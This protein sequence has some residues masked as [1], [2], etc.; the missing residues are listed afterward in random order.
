MPNLLH[1]KIASRFRNR[2][3]ESAK[4][5]E[6]LVLL[7]G[8]FAMLEAGKC[9]LREYGR[10]TGEKNEN[11]CADCASRASEGDGSNLYA[12]WATSY[13]S[14]DGPVRSVPS[15]SSNMPGAASTS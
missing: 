14:S 10:A 12:H 8:R 3:G 15:P 4:A 11:P 1:A 9:V 2:D 13:S 6:F 5:I 7:A